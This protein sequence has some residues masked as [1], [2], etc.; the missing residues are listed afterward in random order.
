M[1]GL[2]ILFFLFGLTTSVK[3][4]IVGIPCAQ[5]HTMHYSQGGGILTEWGTTGPYKALVTKDCIGC[6]TGTNTGANKTPYVLSVDAPAYGET[7]TESTTNTLAGGNFYWV[8]T[9]DSKGHNVEGIAGIDQTWNNIPPG[10]SD[11]GQQLTCAGRY[12]CHGDPNIEGNFESLLGAHHTKDSVIDGSS[13]GKS[14]RFLYQVLGYEDDD[15]EYRPTATE[16]NQYRG[17]DRSSDTQKDP[18]TISALCARCHGDYHQDISSGAWGSPWLR[19]PT[20]YDLGNTALGSEYRNY[21]GNYGS[22]PGAYSVIAPVA[23]EDVSAPKSTVNFQNDTIVTC[24]SCHRAHGTPYPRLLRWNYFGWPGTT[25][26]NGCHACHT[27]KD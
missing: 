22:A 4:G 1:F 27:T 23:S 24:I 14:Y 16:H 13:V 26:V 17:I 25:E 12:G 18:S 21:P 6:H 10:G 9:E 5:C 8:Q 15:W 7:G 20:D 19:H 3:A 2:F 11:L